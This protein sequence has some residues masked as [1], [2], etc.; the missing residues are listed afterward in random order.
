MPAPEN[1][2]I[3]FLTGGLSGAPYP[4]GIAPLGG[5]G[6]FT[7]DGAVQPFRGNT[8]LCPVLRPSDGYE[9]LLWAQ[10]RI[11][12]SEFAP[13]FAF[14]PGP[15]FHMTVFEGATPGRA[16]TADWPSG[17]PADA[18]AGAVDA[19]V[20]ARVRDLALPELA[21]RGTG[22]FCGFSVTLAGQTAAA[23]T[24]LRS[25]RVALREATGI[26]PP[27][28][29][30]YRFHVTLAYLLAWMTEGAARDLVSL[31]DEVFQAAFGQ[32]PKIPL[33]PCNF[34]RF[35]TMHHFEPL[36][37]LRGARIQPAPPKDRPEF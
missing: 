18:T 33:G 36:A 19:A 12:R 29:E 7:P 10:E 27:G 31:S 4:K 8:F 28:F 22:L 25:A 3:A 35:E 11:K 9:R 16:G 20:A 34:C 2:P 17:V 13:F 32:D 15:S 26:S 14:L 30:S 1:D 6:K 24:A 37:A 21:V 23:D 5:G